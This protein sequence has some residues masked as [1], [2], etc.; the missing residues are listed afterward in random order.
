M[1]ALGT[2]KGEQ[3][4]PRNQGSDRTLIKRGENRAYILARLD[5]GLNQDSAVNIAIAANRTNIASPQ[6]RAVLRELS[7]AAVSAWTCTFEFMA[8]PPIKGP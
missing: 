2:A 5:R 4:Q 6:I 1:T 8:N 3:R 7:S